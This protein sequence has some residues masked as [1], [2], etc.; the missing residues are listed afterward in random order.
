MKSLTALKKPFG[1]KDS[2]SRVKRACYLGWEDAFEV[3]FDDG[4]CFLEPH[5][6]IKRANKISKAAVPQR[7]RVPDKYR[8]HFRIDYD[9]G[10][11]AEVSWEFIREL[12]PKQRHQS[13]KGNSKVRSQIDSRDILEARAR[14]QDRPR[15]THAQVKKRYGLK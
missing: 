11:V 9:T 2:F 15:L 12:P 5:A 7:V 4:L 6:T 8:T 3:E 1:S 14:D 10:E 13:R